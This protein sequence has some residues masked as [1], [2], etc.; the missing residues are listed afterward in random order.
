MAQHETMT[1]SV[2]SL[3]GKNALVTGAATGL[4]FAVASGFVES[5][6]RVVIAGRREA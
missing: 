5:G 1:E 4:G 2:N 6:A 3:Q